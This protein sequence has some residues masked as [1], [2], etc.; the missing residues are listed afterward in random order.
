MRV[1]RCCFKHS[2]RNLVI[3]IRWIDRQIRILGLEFILSRMIDVIVESAHWCT[4][5][6]L[7]C[8]HKARQVGYTFHFYGGFYERRNTYQK[9]GKI[10][11]IWLDRKTTHACKG[12]RSVCKIASPYD[13]Y[14]LHRHSS[15]LWSIFSNIPSDQICGLGS[16]FKA[17]TSMWGI[18]TGRYKL[19]TELE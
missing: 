5:N 15:K 19:I 9:G 2:V 1:L 17:L 13:M 12:R 14:V 16:T 8:V 7:I 6:S 3:Q 4:T 11:H 10:W 18:G